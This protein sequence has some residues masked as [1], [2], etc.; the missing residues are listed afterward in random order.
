MKKGRS[1]GRPFFDVLI[2]DVLISDM[3]IS[4][5]LIIDHCCPVKISRVR[6]GEPFTTNADSKNRIR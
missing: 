2:I 1:E 5:V 3:L 6:R 4:D